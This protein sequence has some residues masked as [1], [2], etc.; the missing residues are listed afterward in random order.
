MVVA[1]IA[2]S[3]ALGGVS[4][5]ATALPA[6]SVGTVQLKNNAVKSTKVDNRSLKAIDI[7]AGQLTAARSGGIGICN[8][9]VSTPDLTCAT[10]TLTLPTAGRVLLIAAG[11]WNETGTPD[12]SVLGHCF[13]YA[14]STAVW[15]A[16]YGQKTATFEAGTGGGSP[17]SGTVSMANVTG[18][19]NA[20]THTF[21]VDCRENEGDI[22]FVTLLSGVVLGSS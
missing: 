5:A 20:G 6:N 22:T 10:I 13:L 2:L 18:P 1:C 3:I 21:R 4:Y 14:D 12:G 9:T 7:G 8:P 17:F 16:S 15:T 11:S 19:L